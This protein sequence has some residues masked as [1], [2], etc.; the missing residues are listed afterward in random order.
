M[1]SSRSSSVTNLNTGDLILTILV[2]SGYL[3]L[4]AVQVRPPMPRWHSIE[5][6]RTRGFA[7][8][9]IGAMEWSAGHLKTSGVL[10]YGPRKAEYAFGGTAPRLAVF[11]L[12]R[13]LMFV[14]SVLAVKSSQPPPQ[15]SFPFAFPELPPSVLYTRSPLLSSEYIIHARP[16]C[17]LLFKQ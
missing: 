14:L 11:R 4:L 17:L 8:P 6:L 1:L 3:V 7:P 16:N 2:Q 15:D 13:K 9:A 12:T 5:M 10:I